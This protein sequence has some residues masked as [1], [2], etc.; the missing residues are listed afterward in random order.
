[1]AVEKALECLPASS[2]QSGEFMKLQS[3]SWKKAPAWSIVAKLHG[4]ISAIATATGG[5]GLRQALFA[6]QVWAW[7]ST[8]DLCKTPEDSKMCAYTLRSIMGQL[9]NHRQRQ[10]EV[11]KAWRGRVQTLFE[12]FVQVPSSTSVEPLMDIGDS[13]SDELEDEVCQAKEVIEVSDDDDIDDL[14]SYRAK[15]FGS[16]NAA[17]QHMLL[18]PDQF[19]LEALEKLGSADKA[20]PP[21]PGDWQVL[22]KKLKAK[23]GKVANTKESP[24]S[25]TTTT[26][27][28]T[29]TPWKKFV[30]REHSKVWHAEFKRCIADGQK[31]AKAKKAASISA[32]RCTLE[33]RVRRSAGEFKDLA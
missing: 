30:K 4:T 2:F 8:R 10:R 24:T 11:P 16:P 7:T 18:V 27:T 14:E 6:K 26:T 17:L 1:M 15:V 23:K 22:N 3:Y 9:A 29:T 19:D 31:I 13:S 5:L 12:N 28:T 25:T 21:M 32:R 33:L 20:M